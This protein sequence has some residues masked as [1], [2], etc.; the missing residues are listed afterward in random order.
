M[1]YY[2][3][4]EK[5]FL[6]TI[7]RNAWFYKTRGQFQS[8]NAINTKPLSDGAGINVYEIEDSDKLI[9]AVKIR[10]TSV[11][12]TRI[13]GMFEWRDN[14]NPPTVIRKY[15]FQAVIYNHVN[16]KG[17]NINCIAL[18]CTL[19]QLIY[20]DLNGITFV[21]IFSLLPS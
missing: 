9:P 6:N 1:D 5:G 11:G 3:N 2:N 18:L 15:P 20:S 8:G 19:S 17:L 12:C 4:N 13:S 16:V 21:T 14:I 7:E 10:G